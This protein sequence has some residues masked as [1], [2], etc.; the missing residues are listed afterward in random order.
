M[1]ENG[2]ESNGKRSGLYEWKGRAPGIFG[3]VTC[4]MATNQPTDDSELLVLAA[5]QSKLIQSNP[6]QHDSHHLTRLDNCRWQQPKRQRH[7]DNS[8]NSTY[9]NPLI[10]HIPHMQPPLM[11]A[12]L[13][14]VILEYEHSALLTLSS[15]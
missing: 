3:D 6:I 12:C 5:R 11:P 8:P 14:C 2:G 13:P 15:F 1:R 10:S 9:S 4:N 7:D